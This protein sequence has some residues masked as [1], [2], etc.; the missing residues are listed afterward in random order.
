MQEIIL[1]V[2]QHLDEKYQ[3]RGYKMLMNCGRAAGQQV[4][5]FHLHLLPF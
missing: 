1:T 3:P 4:F 2:K 5:H